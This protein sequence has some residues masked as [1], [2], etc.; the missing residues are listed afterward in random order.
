MTPEESEVLR[1]L[2]QA[3][4]KFIELPAMHHMDNHEF[5]HA[6]HAAQ[7][8]VLA[9]AG[10]RAQGSIRLEPDNRVDLVA[11]DGIVGRVELDAN[12]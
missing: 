6:I 7:N 10:L 2:G 4:N 11:A 3:W 8:I 5:C 9:R 12:S 1:L